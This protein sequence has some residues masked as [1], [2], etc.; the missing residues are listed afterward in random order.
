MWLANVLTSRGKFQEA[1]NEL[2]RL[3][4]SDPLSMGVQFTLSE[5]YLS[6]RKPDDA[7]KAAHL[8]RELGA[9]DSI[10]DRLF[11]KAYMQKGDLEQ[12]RNLLERKPENFESLRVTWLARIGKTGEAAAE[13]KRLETTETGKTSPFVIAYLY[14]EL[15]DK[16]RA[17]KW[18]ERSYAIRQSDLVSLKIEPSL[19]SIRTDPRYIDILKRVNLDH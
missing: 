14:A 13:L 17:F 6:W 2:M 4:E 12:V 9:P 15:G 8:V 5:L 19:D 7:I 11:A 3:Q 1:E 16:D 18:L 10:S